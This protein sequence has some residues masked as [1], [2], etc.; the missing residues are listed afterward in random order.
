[1]Q[2]LD[3]VER[4]ELRTL[5]ETAVVPATEVTQQKAL[6]EQLV[7]EGLLSH[8][9]P[10]KKDLN[11]FLRWDPIPIKGKPLSETIIEERR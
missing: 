11:R 6:R 8:V 9:P 1:M 10:R 4:R 2:S 5:L 3:D 7:V